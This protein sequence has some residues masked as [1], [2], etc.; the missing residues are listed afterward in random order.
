MVA[1]A[2]ENRDKVTAAISAINNG[3]AE[4]VSAKANINDVAI[5][6]R[7]MLTA[8]DDAVS[9]LQRMASE[10]DQA[11]TLA[12][13]PT[14]GTFNQDAVTGLMWLREMRD[15]TDTE[16]QRLQA[17]KQRI[18]DDIG[19]MDHIIQSIDEVRHKI[20]G[21]KNNFTAYANTLY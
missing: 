12:V 9:A 5:Y 10:I 15:N 17:M 16:I 21:A 2:A 13:R 6:S 11:W 19:K 4:Y 7:T 20:Q 1:S 14:E 3:L 18:K 8:I